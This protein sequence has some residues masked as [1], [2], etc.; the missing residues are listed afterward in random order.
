MIS[1]IDIGKRLKSTHV[2]TH[3]RTHARTHFRHPPDEQF[4]HVDIYFLATTII[5]SLSTLNLGKSFSLNF[6]DP[7]DSRGCRKFRLGNLLPEAVFLAVLACENCE[8][9][10]TVLE[11]ILC[12]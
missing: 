6:R 8:S 9:K 11:R 12:L 1:S 4:R 2:R 3:A 10:V 7:F 5:C